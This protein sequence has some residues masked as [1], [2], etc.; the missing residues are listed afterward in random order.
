MRGSKPQVICPPEE[1]VTV[2]YGSTHN[3]DAKKHQERMM[4]GSAHI[5]SVRKAL[6]DAILQGKCIMLLVI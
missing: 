2:V 4:S 6:M 1:M 3:R 5:A